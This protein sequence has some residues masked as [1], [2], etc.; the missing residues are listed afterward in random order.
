MD[1][2]PKMT[3]FFDGVIMHK[4]RGDD[5]CEVLE[6]GLSVVNKA[7]GALQQ[8]FAAPRCIWVYFFALGLRI[9]FS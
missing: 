8:Q 9:L 2:L 5:C 6:A 1:F 7:K 3:L 4:R